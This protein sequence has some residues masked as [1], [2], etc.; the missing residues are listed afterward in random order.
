M[1][2][3][4]KYSSVHLDEKLSSVTGDSAAGDQRPDVAGVRN[5]TGGVDTV[6]HPSKSQSEKQMD[7][8]G[9]AMQKKLAAVGRAGNHETR[10][11]SKALSGKSGGFGEI[12]MLVTVAAAGAELL[13]N[14][15]KQGAADAAASV[16]SGILCGAMGGCANA[17][18]ATDPNSL[19]R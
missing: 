2:K 4:G 16:V 13:Q 3:S 7:K 8:K 12:G 19:A 5:D 15:S 11:I 9:V 10:P 1:A 17:G 6:E 18:V 14:P